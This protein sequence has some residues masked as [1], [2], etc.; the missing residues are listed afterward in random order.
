MKELLAVL[1]ERLTPIVFDAIQA[2]QQT[3]TTPVTREQIVADLTADIDRILGEG[4]AWRAT[5]PTV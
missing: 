1:I 5:H 2:R 4:D 3:Q